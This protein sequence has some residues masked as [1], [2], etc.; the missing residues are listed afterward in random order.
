MHVKHV[1]NVTLL[2]I[3]CPTDICL[4]VTKIRAKVNTMQILTFYFLFVHGP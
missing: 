1:A 3:I 2:Y 4:N